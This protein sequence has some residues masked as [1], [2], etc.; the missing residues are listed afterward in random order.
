[1]FRRPRQTEPDRLPM[2]LAKT[3]EPLAVV[4]WRSLPWYVSTNL[5]FANVRPKALTGDYTVGGLAGVLEGSL[6]CL[7]SSN[8]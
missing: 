4:P 8:F 3:L 2:R 6:K 7:L 5:N 1:M